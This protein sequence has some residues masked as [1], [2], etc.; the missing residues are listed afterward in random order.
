MSNACIRL[1]WLEQMACNAL[2]PKMSK[3]TFGHIT[4]PMITNS[5]SL[6]HSLINSAVHPAY[7]VERTLAATCHHVSTAADQPHPPHPRPAQLSLISFPTRG[8]QLIECNPILSLYST[9]HPILQNL[10]FL[11]ENYPRS[12]KHKV[13]YVVSPSSTSKTFGVWVGVQ[14]S[15]FKV[16][17]SMI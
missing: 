16:C 11:Q 15:S 2:S 12:H 9:I 3:L 1:T 17:G 6:V 14:G 5:T 4:P 7:L 13:I 8:W 10:A